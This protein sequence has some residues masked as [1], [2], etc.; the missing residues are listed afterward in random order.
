MRKVSSFPLTCIFVFGIGKSGGEDAQD[1]R[2]QCRARDG[3]SPRRMWRAWGCVEAWI[4]RWPLDR[5]EASLEQIRAVGFHVCSFL[6]AQSGVDEENII[7]V[8]DKF[9]GGLSVILI[10]PL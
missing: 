1:L 9:L 4:R 3:P 6:G 5:G 7:S 10:G 8:R 2:R